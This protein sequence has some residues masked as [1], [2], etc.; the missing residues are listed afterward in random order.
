M[1]HA[2]GHL[3]VE[4]DARL[5]GH[6]HHAQLGR[7]HPLGEVAGQR[8]PH[9]GHIDAAGGEF[10]LE[11]FAGVLGRVGA[12]HGEGHTLLHQLVLD[13]PFGGGGFVEHADA[14]LGQAFR[15][16]C[17]EIGR[18][19]DAVQ[20]LALGEDQRVGGAVQRLRD[21]NLV[22]AHRHAHDDVATEVFAGQLVAQG[23]ADEGQAVGEGKIGDR[24]AQGLAEHIGQLVLDAFS[25]EVG[26][27][28]VV[29]V[30]ADLE[31]LA[32]RGVLRLRTRHGPQQARQ[33]GQVT[34][35]SGHLISSTLE[36][37][38][39]PSERPFR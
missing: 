9:D 3:E 35:A 38:I 1:A 18:A 19:L 25:R 2:Q 33:G 29:R 23:V 13:Q 11:D 5:G 31:R 14:H 24:Q 39:A 20:A 32:G 4:L 26:E 27:G 8:A 21:R 36:R 12:Q 15:A 28:H 22:K 16:Q 37:V 17:E 34:V 30:L 10:L 6:R 7:L